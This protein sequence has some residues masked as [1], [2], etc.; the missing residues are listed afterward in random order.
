MVFVDPR[1]VPE[2]ARLEKFTSIQDTGVWMLA[3]KKKKD[4]IGLIKAKANAVR[5]ATDVFFAVVP[6]QCNPAY[7]QVL[8]GSADP[9][10][11]PYHI[12]TTQGVRCVVAIASSKDEALQDMHMLLAVP[13][14]PSAFKWS[15]SQDVSE[16]LE[17]SG[18]LLKDMSLLGKHCKTCLVPY[19]L[20]TANP[21]PGWSTCRDLAHACCAPLICRAHFCRAHMCHP[22]L[23]PR[24][25]IWGSAEATAAAGEAAEAE[26]TDPAATAA[27][28]LS[29]LD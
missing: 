10:D 28:A 29:C 12:R 7:T 6:G 17:S 13:Q 5:G 24:C 11:K 21:T 25:V 1:V 14:P 2:D 4:G 9:L 8:T 15:T 26:G 22:H 27:P 3:Q 16:Y 23:I 18:L 19:K 20:L